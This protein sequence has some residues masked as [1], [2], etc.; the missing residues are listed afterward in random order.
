MCKRR[1]PA[2]TKEKDSELF[3]VH[4][5]RERHDTAKA[6]A[7]QRPR[8][9]SSISTIARCEGEL[10]TK[11]LVAEPFPTMAEKGTGSTTPMTGEVGV[12]PVRLCAKVMHAAPEAEEE[13]PAAEKLEETSQDTTDGGDC[14]PEDAEFF[15]PRRREINRHHIKWRRYTNNGSALVAGRLTQCVPAVFLSLRVTEFNT[16][17]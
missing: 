15:I 4:Y 8:N 11:V 13:A 10:A 5:L 2:D 14:H 16:N 1:E 12:T 17:V 7:F 3:K 6:L 9:I